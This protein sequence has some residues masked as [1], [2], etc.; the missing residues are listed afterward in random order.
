MAVEVSQA[1]EVYSESEKT[2]KRMIVTKVEDNTVT[3]RYEGVF[4]FITADVTEME[5]DPARFRPA[6]APEPTP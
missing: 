4:E 2:W 5:S 1:W 3:L 6:S